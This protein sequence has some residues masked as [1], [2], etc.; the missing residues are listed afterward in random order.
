MPPLLPT[1]TLGT[2]SPKIFTKQATRA[3]LY[4][5]ERTVRQF[6]MMIEGNERSEKILL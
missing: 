5:L 6:G 3:S 4:L 2:A 1:Q